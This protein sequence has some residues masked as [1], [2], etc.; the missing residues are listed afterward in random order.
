MNLGDFPFIPIKDIALLVRLC[1]III[2]EVQI[3]SNVYMTDLLE[4]SRLK[5]LLA[6]ID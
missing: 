1:M 6:F 5:S 4:S 2:S 3:R